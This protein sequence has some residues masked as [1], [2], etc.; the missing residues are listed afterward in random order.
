MLLLSMLENGRRAQIIHGSIGTLTRMGTLHMVV[1]MN[2]IHIQIGIVTSSNR[3]QYSDNGLQGTLYT[4]W[5][6]IE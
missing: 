2:Q 4:R 1:I 3:T 5:K 6:G